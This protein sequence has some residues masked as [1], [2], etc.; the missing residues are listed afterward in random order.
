M[1]LTIKA[2]IGITTNGNGQIQSSE[3]SKNN[4]ASIF[5]GNTNFASDQID[6]KRKEAQ[7]KAMKVVQDAWNN[8]KS[9]DAGIE[10]RKNH[11]KEMETTMGDAKKQIAALKG[12]AD[13]LKQMNGVTDDFKEQIDLE[14][15]K[16]RQAS[17]QPNAT[18]RLTEDEVKQ[19]KIIDEQPVTEYQKQALK[20]NEDTFVFEKTIRDAEKQRNDDLRDIEAIKQERLKT[21][22]M[23]DAQKSADSIMNA[24][25]DQI[26]DMLIEESKDSIDEKTED[27]E[28]KIKE[29]EEDKQKE[30]ELEAIKDQHIMEEAIAVGTKEAVEEAKAEVD[31]N[32]ATNLDLNNM[33]DIA[34]AY[35]QT[36]GVQ[37]S[38]AEIKVNMKLLDADLKGIQV[39]ETV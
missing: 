39:D 25:K 5:V 26:V 23:V 37:K 38:L 31:N 8:D 12:K 9:I 19:L 18:V 6:E 10:K 29:N 17:L 24:V 1:G 27:N 13:E 30:D 3:K 20:Y 16:K 34:Q 33:I 11:A 14:L 28:E 21:H 7:K 36:S 4:V 15:L 32:D 2:D 22:P 35:T